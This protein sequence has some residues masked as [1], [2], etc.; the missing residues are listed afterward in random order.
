MDGQRSDLSY[1]IETSAV[2]LAPGVSLLL[3]RSVPIDWLTAVMIPAVIG[4]VAGAVF[5]RRWHWAVIDAF[6]ATVV[7]V[8]W[9][10]VYL[11]IV[12]QGSNECL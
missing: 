4:A 3:L 10:F 12:C 5:H 8:P 11:T 9:A 6:L 2:I 7:A 1:V